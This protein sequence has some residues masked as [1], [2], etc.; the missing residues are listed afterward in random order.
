M[1]P[2]CPWWLSFWNEGRSYS[3]SKAKVLRRL[4]RF[5]WD[6]DGE[7]NLG[8]DQAQRGPESQVIGFSLYSVGHS[9]RNDLQKPYVDGRNML[10]PWENSLGQCH[11]WKR[12]GDRDSW[13][14]HELFTWEDW[15]FELGLWQWE[16]CTSW[17]TAGCEERLKVLKLIESS[18]LEKRYGSRTWTLAMALSEN[19]RYTYM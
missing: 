16:C 11:P 2:R 10:G 18:K 4:G 1:P 5:Q 3:D 8:W 7:T 19:W 6:I 12:Y 15:G 13:Q 9:H 17:N 14:G